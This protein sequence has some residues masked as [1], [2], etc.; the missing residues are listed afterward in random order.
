[1]EVDTG[2]SMTLISKA[3]FDSLWDPQNAPSLQPTGSKL[4]TYTG[5]N[6]EVLDAANVSVSFQ[7]QHK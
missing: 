3:T 2:A 5:E 4:R 6:I 7:E 1:M